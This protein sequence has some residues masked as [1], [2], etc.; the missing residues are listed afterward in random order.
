MPSDSGDFRVVMRDVPLPEGL[1]ERVGALADSLSVPMKDVLLAAHLKVLSLVSGQSEVTTGYEHSGR[2]E[3][4]GA[5]TTLG[6]HLNS[7]PLR[8]R[9]ELNPTGEAV[10]DAEAGESWAQLI[11]R[12]YQAELDL[13]PHRRYPMARM[14]QDLSTQRQLFDTTFNFTHFYLMKNLRQLPEFSLLQI[15]VDSETEFPF[16][17]EFSR[18]YTDDELRLCLHYHSHLYA[19]AQ[20]DRVGGYFVRVLELMAGEPVAPHAARP[21]LAAEDAALIAAQGSL[22]GA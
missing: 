4:P 21:L 2:P 1:T 15:Q 14:K 6:L 12:V 20:I 17:T 18:H 11:R 16:R 13:L 8:L 5:E 7:V 10:Q 19:E 3:L 9:M 22:G